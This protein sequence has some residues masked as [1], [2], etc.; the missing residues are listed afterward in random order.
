MAHTKKGFILLRLL[1]LEERSSF[2]AVGTL[3]FGVYKKSLEDES[4]PWKIVKNDEIK[5]NKYY[6]DV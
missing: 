1:N 5:I 2:V 6:L 3:K 4:P